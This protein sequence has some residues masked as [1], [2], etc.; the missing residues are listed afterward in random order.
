MK[1]VILTGASR[2][3][4]LT[5]AKNLKKN[6]FKIIAIGRQLS[7]ELNDLIEDKSIP[8]EIIFYPYDFSYSK[9]IYELTKE[10]KKDHGAVFGLVNNA[11]VGADGILA[12]MHE[13]QIKETINV[14]LVSPMILT[15]YVSRSMLANGCGRIINISS[16]IANTG[17]NGLSVYASSKGGLVSFGK[18]LARELG[19]AEVTVNNILPGY[20]T[21]DMTKDIRSVELEAIKRRSPLGR[22]V[23]TQ[24]VAS[25]VNY[26]MSDDAKNIT[27]IN[28]IIDAGNTI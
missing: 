4:G 6:K 17:F 8:G 16:I 18:S 28:M 27:G 25:A 13:K 20:M 10:I 3:L 23:S 1:T 11:A 26:L 5:I 24:D 2:G 7:E 19:K 9:G 22:L 21:T 15:K 12:T 14:N